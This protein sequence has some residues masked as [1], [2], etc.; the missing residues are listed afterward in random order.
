MGRLKA[1]GP[2][3]SRLGLRW[4]VQSVGGEHAFAVGMWRRN[5]VVGRGVC[6]WTWQTVEREENFRAS[7]P[8]G[9][10]HRACHA[11]TS[12]RLRQAATTG[13]GRANSS[14]GEVRQ[15]TRRD[16]VAAMEENLLYNEG[17]GQMPRDRWPSSLGELY[18]N[19]RNVLKFSLDVPPLSV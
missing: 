16:R 14:S 15:T 11:R 17:A 6:G 7:I 9:R 2:L 1:A 5:H 10:D 19:K 8:G 12:G 18:Q 13:E 4:L 3:Q